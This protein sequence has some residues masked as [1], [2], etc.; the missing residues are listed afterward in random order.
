MQSTEPMHPA[1]ELDLALLEAYGKTPTGFKGKEWA[2]RP[3]VLHPPLGLIKDWYPSRIKPFIGG[4]LPYLA[5]PTQQ[6]KMSHN[7]ESLLERQ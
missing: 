4:L 6:G 7:E 3:P 5:L 2:V 1:S